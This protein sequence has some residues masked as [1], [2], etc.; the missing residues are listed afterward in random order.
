MGERENKENYLSRFP[1]TMPY[2]WEEAYSVRLV[3][4]LSN[5]DSAT[6]Q[7]YIG[8][9]NESLDELR[10]NRLTEEEL[11]EKVKL[12]VFRNKFDE[13][14]KD[15]LDHLKQHLNRYNAEQEKQILIEEKFAVFLK[16]KEARLGVSAKN[17]KKER[18]GGGKFNLPDRYELFRRIFKGEDILMQMNT[19]ATNKHILLAL[20]LGCNQQTARELFNGTQKNRTQVQKDLIDNYLKTLE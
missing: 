4:F 5:N 2:K 9:L 8:L 17:A 12:R 14:N 1:L 11:I 13:N 15:H 3:G 7:E 19:S 18:L 6:E 20:I 16:S 10:E